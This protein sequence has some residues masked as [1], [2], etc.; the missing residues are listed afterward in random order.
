MGKF[1]YS[2]GCNEFVKD[3]LRKEKEAGTRTN[4]DVFCTCTIIGN[5]SS[6]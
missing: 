3:V 1:T 4:V 5:E 6:H 2:D